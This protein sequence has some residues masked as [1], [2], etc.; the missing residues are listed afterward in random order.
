MHSNFWLFKIL[1]L[2]FFFFLQ[3]FKA[4]KNKERKKRNKGVQPWRRWNIQTPLTDTCVFY[5]FQYS[6][7]CQSTKFRLHVT[8]CPR[9]S[10][11][12]RAGATE[13]LCFSHSV[14]GQLLPSSEVVDE[15]RHTVCT[16][17]VVWVSGERFV[18]PSFGITW[19]K[20]RHTNT[21]S[22]GCSRHTSGISTKG[23]QQHIKI[24]SFRCNFVSWSVLEAWCHETRTVWSNIRL[25]SLWRDTTVAAVGQNGF[26]F[27][28]KPPPFSSLL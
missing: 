23:H 19:N 24:N 25:P 7:Q 27:G 5:Y 1:A 15:H 2:I 16:H 18:L 17:Q 11:R 26:G 22:S 21:M 3:A 4:P 8:K 10:E 14:T 28:P 20:H 9:L 6:K 12:S 13:V